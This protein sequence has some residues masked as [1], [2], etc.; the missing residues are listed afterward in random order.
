MSNIPPP[1]PGSVPQPAPYMDGDSVIHVAGI[2]H[3]PYFPDKAERKALE[4]KG[5]DVMDNA[6]HWPWQLMMAGE[7]IARAA[8]SNHIP[9]EVANRLLAS[10]QAAFGVSL[11]PN[12]GKYQLIIDEPKA[13]EVTKVKSDLPNLRGGKLFTSANLDSS[14]VHQGSVSKEIER[15]GGLEQLRLDLS[16][17][18]GRLGLHGA[19]V[20]VIPLENGISVSKKHSDKDSS[21]V[22]VAEINPPDGSDDSMLTASLVEKNNGNYTQYSVTRRTDLDSGDVTGTVQ[23]KT[24]KGVL[25]NTVSRS[26]K[27]SKSGAPITERALKRLAGIKLNN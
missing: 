16:I 9:Y 6:K 4:T 10:N 26:T 8:D 22:V 5:I 13:H 14:L 21:S 3:G 7:A 1:P 27:F 12:A 18:Y 24:K 20:E 15:V 17:E 11:D 2:D 23:V 25:Y 19:D